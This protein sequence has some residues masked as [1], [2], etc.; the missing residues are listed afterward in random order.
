MRIVWVIWGIASVQTHRR[1][2][3]MTDINGNINV[4]C[5]NNY[6]RLG[7]LQRERCHWHIEFVQVYSEQNVIFHFGDQTVGEERLPYDLRIRWII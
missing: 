7:T 5:D 4:R 6:L 2:E 1:Q 3:R